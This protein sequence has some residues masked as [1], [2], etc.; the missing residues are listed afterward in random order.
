MEDEENERSGLAE[1]VSA[2]G[3]QMITSQM[4]CRSCNTYFEAIRDAA[5]DLPDPGSPGRSLADAWRESAGFIGV[6][7]YATAAG[8]RDELPV[9][10]L[11]SG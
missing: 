10:I 2:W 8:A 6:Q 3:G 7:S 5:R 11:G 4:R 1:L 9:A